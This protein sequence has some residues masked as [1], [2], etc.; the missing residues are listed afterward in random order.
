[1]LTAVLTDVVRS[2]DAALCLGCSAVHAPGVAVELGPRGVLG[3][4]DARSA[5][6]AMARG[7]VT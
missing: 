5:S 4:H 6:Q 2:V 3:E 7:L 1:M